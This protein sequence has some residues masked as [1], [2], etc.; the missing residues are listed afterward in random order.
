MDDPVDTGRRVSR[1]RLLGIGLAGAAAAALAAL[2]ADRTKEATPVVGRSGRG[3]Q[4]EAERG[5]RSGRLTARPQQSA[6]G[7][8]PLGVQ[9]LGLDAGRDGLVYVPASYRADR[10]APLALMLHGAGGNADH[11][12][13]L[14]RDLADDAGLIL[15]APESRGPTWDVI[16]GGYGPDVAFIDRALEQTFSRYAVDPGRVAVGGFSDGA[17]YALSI[18]ITNGDLLGHVIAFS[19]GFA[20]PA[21][22]TGSPRIFV[23]H[24]T[25][26]QVLPID[27]CSRRI[28]PMLRRSGYDVTY[29][30]FDG[31]HVV[32]P[33]MA[34]QGV[35]W[36]LHPGEGG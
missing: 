22:T 9:R 27:S 5:A 35:A 33:D 11:G 20:A 7:A 32:P 16:R 23:S 24:G 2:G 1:R 25:G 8:A 6:A 30:E 3:S 15:V 14:I 4:N 12:L 28:V 29:Q 17:S 34:R 21:G 13:G 10:P 19:P 26:D 36:F 31:P 18:G